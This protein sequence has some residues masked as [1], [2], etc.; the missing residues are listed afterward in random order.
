MRQTVRWTV[1]AAMVGCLA[2]PAAAANLIE[3]SSLGLGLGGIWREDAGVGAP[4]DFEAGLRGAI[5]LTPHVSVVGGVHYGIDQSY[6]R[7]SGGVRLTATDASDQTFSIGI[8][9]S[10]HYRS[11]PGVGIDEAAAEAAV[12]WQPLP[13]S[14]IL[15][16]AVAAYGF[17]TRAQI[18]TFSVVYPLKKA[19]GG[20]Q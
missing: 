3:A 15:L 20:A 9:V 8:G 12:G 17:D 5:S 1:L 16:A 4:R 13:G 2:G 7:G 18:Y 19:S 10:R 14:K 11:E 6:V